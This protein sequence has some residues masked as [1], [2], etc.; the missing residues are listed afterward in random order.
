MG[1]E[2]TIVSRRKIPLC[3]YGTGTRPTKSWTSR[4]WRT[5]TTE[6]ARRAS[7]T[8]KSRRTALTLRTIAPS[9][10]ISIISSPDRCFGL[11]CI[12]K[13]FQILNQLRI[14]VA[15]YDRSE[16]VLGF[17]GRCRQ[18]IRIGSIP[19]DSRTRYGNLRSIK[20]LGDRL[21]RVDRFLGIAD[22]DHALDS[23]LFVFD[24][25]PMI[26]SNLIENLTGLVRQFLRILARLNRLGCESHVNQAGAQQ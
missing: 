26:F 15:D 12:F 11:L 7:A 25:I 6:Q 18:D 19:S 8:Q 9:C 4:T 10:T 1:R 23:G 24:R 14:G 22:V 16:E 2:A 13:F 5:A 3:G 20:I 17:Q 21:G